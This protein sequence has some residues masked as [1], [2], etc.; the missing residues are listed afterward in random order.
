[1][2]TNISFYPIGQGW[3][4]EYIDDNYYRH[5]FLGKVKERKGSP[6]DKDRTD[7]KA[8]ISPILVREHPGCR[9]SNPRPTA[10]Y[11]E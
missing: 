2:D 1:M 7:A 8:P 9:P 5:V 10:T 3:Y 11:R 6:Y 4:L